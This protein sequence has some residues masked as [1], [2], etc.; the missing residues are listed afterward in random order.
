[1]RFLKARVNTLSSQPSIF[2]ALLQ[3]ASAA[4]AGC[5]QYFERQTG[6]GFNRVQRIRHYP[7][8]NSFRE[9]LTQEYLRTKL[10]GGGGDGI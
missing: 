9:S 7:L 1:M 10:K 8:D 3:S 2:K 5:L 6:K 4:V